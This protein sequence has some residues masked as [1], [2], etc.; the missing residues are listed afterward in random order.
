M[1]PDVIHVLISKNGLSRAQFP[2]EDHSNSEV[3]YIFAHT[4]SYLAKTDDQR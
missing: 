3:F 4:S 2:L 1:V